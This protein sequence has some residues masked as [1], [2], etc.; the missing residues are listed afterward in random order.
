MIFAFLESIFHD[1]A[2]CLTL[3]KKDQDQYIH[4]RIAPRGARGIQESEIIQKYDFDS[5][6]VSPE[7][8][9]E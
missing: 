6:E 1:L 8:R 4:W 7:V 5:F 2:H 3:D 9:T